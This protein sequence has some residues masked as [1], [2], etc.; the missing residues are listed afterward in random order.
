[1]C[2]P[3]SISIFN[4]FV[5]CLDP[6]SISVFEEVDQI[7]QNVQSIKEYALV[8][9]SVSIL[10]N[11]ILELINLLQLQAGA[12]LHEGVQRLLSAVVFVGDEVSQLGLFHVENL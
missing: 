4:F 9:Q 6:F 11:A 10:I 5:I 1:M 2:L 8:N 3:I 12:Y 7:L